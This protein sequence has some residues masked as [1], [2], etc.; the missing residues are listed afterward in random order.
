MKHPN[1]S[2]ACEGWLSLP[3]KK[4]KAPEMKTTQPVKD[5]LTEKVE[6]AIGEGEYNQMSIFSFKLVDCN[7]SCRALKYNI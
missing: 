6:E 5:N 4:G 3:D 2:P 7:S 1:C